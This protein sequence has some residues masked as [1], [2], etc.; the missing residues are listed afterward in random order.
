MTAYDAA[1]N[2]VFSSGNVADRQDP[3]DI[4]DPV[5]DCADAE[6]TPANKK[7][8]GLWDRM[9]KHDG[10]RADFFWEVANEP[11]Y[12]PKPDTRT[13]ASE[14]AFAHSTTASGA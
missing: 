11:S 6:H 9:T 12:L 1:N 4:N 5:V 8:S 2:S 10:T 3:E 7:C 13:V 14:P